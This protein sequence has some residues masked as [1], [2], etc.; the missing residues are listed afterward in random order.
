MRASKRND[1]QFKSVDATGG[2]NRGFKRNLGHN[3]N[4]SSSIGINGRLSPRA[5]PMGSTSR[6]RLGLGERKRS[7]KLGLD[8][9]A[10]RTYNRNEKTQRST[11][12]SKSQHSWVR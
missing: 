3:L 8:N 11:S 2:G 9:M 4:N 6:K 1:W 12:L 10:V 5:S 7:S